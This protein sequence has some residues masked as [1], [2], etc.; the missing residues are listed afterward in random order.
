M[1]VHK[2]DGEAMKP[3]RAIGAYTGTARWIISETC[4]PE[5]RTSEIK[6]M[7]G[8]SSFNISLIHSQYGK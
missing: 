2:M 6:N 5:I 4:M 3:E 1:A 8:Q 7:R